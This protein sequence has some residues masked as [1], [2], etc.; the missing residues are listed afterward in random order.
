[1]ENSY[2]R[3]KANLISINALNHIYEYLNQCNVETIDLSELL[4]AEYVLI[5]SA[6][7]SLVHDMVR[8]GLLR[9]FENENCDKS[10]DKFQISLQVAKNILATDS[11]TERTRLLNLEIRKITSKDSY[12]SPS[13]IESALQLLSITKIWSKLSLVISIPSEDIK[14]QLAIIIDRRNKIAHEADWNILM[15][16]KN[17][18]GNEDLIIVREFIKKISNALFTIVQDEIKSEC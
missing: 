3:F 4:R 15:N 14:K 9:I 17:P 10:L 13:S 6:F 7:D 18:I 12:Q 11:L 16:E 5:V 8:S 2:S 1:M